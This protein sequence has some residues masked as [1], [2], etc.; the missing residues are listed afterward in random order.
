VTKVKLEIN[1]IKIKQHNN[2]KRMKK[3][4]DK[5]YLKKFILFN[6]MIIVEYILII[7]LMNI[8]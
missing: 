2:Q 3:I 5:K 7:E 6:V 1:E 4:N 8:V